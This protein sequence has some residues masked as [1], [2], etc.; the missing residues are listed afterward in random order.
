VRFQSAFF[1]ENQNIQEAVSRGP[2]GGSSRN[3]SKQ[4]HW[5]RFY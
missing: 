1:S 3:I 2:G 4:E 5:R